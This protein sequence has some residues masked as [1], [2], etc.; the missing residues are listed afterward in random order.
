MLRISEETRGSALVCVLEGTL[1]GPWVRELELTC[2]RAVT[3]EPSL[4]IR[5][6]LSGLTFVSAEGKELLQRCYSA[7]MQLMSS[8]VLTKAIIDEI[9]RRH[10]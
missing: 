7:G 3:A 10:S 6:D 8:D 9:S 2:Q 1:T 4:K 5:L